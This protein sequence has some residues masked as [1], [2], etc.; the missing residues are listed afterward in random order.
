MFNTLNRHRTHASKLR[1]CHDETHHLLAFSVADSD[2]ATAPEILEAIQ[3][4][5]EHG[6]FG[7]TDPCSDYPLVYANWSKRRYHLEVDPEWLV[8]SSK[9]LTSLSLL[10]E[11]LTNEGDDVVLFSPVYHNFY[12]V[13]ERTQRRIVAS[14]LKVDDAGRYTM[15]LEDLTLRFKQGA[16]TLIFCHPHNP[17]GRVW[18]HEELSAMLALCDTHGVTVISDE[19]HSDIVMPEV[20]FS[21]VLAFQEH[22]E[23]VIILQAISKTFNLAGLQFSHV[24]IPNEGVRH[25]F[26]V[27]LAR[28]FLDTPNV[29][30]LTAASAAYRTG[31][32]WVDAQN[33]HIAANYLL[34]KQ[35][36]AAFPHLTISP[37]EGTYLAW[38]NATYYHQRHSNLFETLKE[39]G[40]L[41][42]KGSDY[43]PCCEGYLRWN[44][45]CS[46]AQLEEGLNRVVDVFGQLDQL[47]T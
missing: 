27:A 1:D 43:A 26:K 8:L 46:S 16:K 11:M 29:F 39:I 47:N 13:I 21:S 30:A 23:S 19:V 2:Y 37:L 22:H 36:L 42:C 10:L 44:L 40:V 14:P 34:L 6:A 20:S 41:F 45:A 33:E 31:D 32:A 28:Q 9:V 18:S 15:D 35:T 38:I 24:I 4:R 25:R 12:T 3:A 7:Y 5:A 17:I